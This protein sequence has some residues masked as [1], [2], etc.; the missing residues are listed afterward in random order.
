MKAALRSACV[1]VL[2]VLLAATASPAV[3]KGPTDVT[4]SGPGVDTAVSWTDRAGDVDVGSLA[5]AARIGR[6][7]D[8]SGLAPSPRL[9]ADQLGPRYLL[10]WTAGGGPWAVQHAYPFAEGGAWVRFLSV[11]A[12]GPGGWTR[13]PGLQDQ[14]VRLGAA[15]QPIAPAFAALA[16][17]SVLSCLL[18]W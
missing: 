11:P 1:A 5:D 17:W 8:G 14:L 7:W 10:T 13:A 9:T 4:V 18:W 2:S 12:G 6:H 16:P 15:A 3:A